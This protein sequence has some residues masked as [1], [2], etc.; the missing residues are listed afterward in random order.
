MLD[1]NYVR[2]QRLRRGLRQDLETALSQVDA[3]ITPTTRSVAFPI[4]STIPEIGGMPLNPFN[5]GV[6]LTVPFDLTGTPNLPVPGGFSSDG[7]P[8]GSP[9]WDQATV[10]RI[11]AAYEQATPCHQQHPNL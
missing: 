9:A 1:A 7:L 5:L 4:G 2:G 8:I 11:G 10:L 6:G 3:I